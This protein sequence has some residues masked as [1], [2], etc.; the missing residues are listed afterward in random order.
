[1]SYIVKIT[2][3]LDRSKWSRFRF[4]Y[5][6]YIEDDSPLK[7]SFV[8]LG[9]AIDRQLAEKRANEIVERHKAGGILGTE[10]T[11]YRTD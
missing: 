3:N 7:S 2:E 9:W 5:N 4:S 1:M 8:G 6:V 11:T 10:T